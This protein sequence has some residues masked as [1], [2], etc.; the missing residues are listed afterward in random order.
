MEVAEK[1]FIGAAGKA[2]FDADK[3]PYVTAEA[4]KRGNVVFGPYERYYETN[5]YEV[6]FYIL[7]GKDFI[8]DGRNFCQAD[9][10]HSEYP[11]DKRVIAGANINSNASVYEGVMRVTLPFSIEWPGTLQ[12]RLHSLGTHNFAVKYRRDVNIAGQ[13]GEAVEHSE[14]Y[15]A[16]LSNFRR[17]SYL[18]AKITDGVDEILF[19]WLGIRCLIK[20]DEDLAIIND[21]LN[22]NNYKFAIAGEFCVIDI[23]MNVGL[24]SLY[25]ARMPAV[26]A[27]H[28]FEPF[29]RPF[30][31]ALANFALN[32]ELS[33]K[34]KPHQIGLSGKTEV[35]EVAVDPERT[36]GTS[37]RG[38]VAG[39]VVDR[40]SIQDATE[41][42]EPI[43]REA[44]RKKQSIVVKMDCEGSEFGIFDSLQKSGLLR[45][46]NIF[47]I[48]CHK[49]WSPD[50]SNETL[51]K[52]LVANGFS[53]FDFNHM[54]NAGASLIYASRSGVI[55]RPGW[56]AGRVSE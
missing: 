3:E 32:P 41:A 38:R 48:E 42:L 9:V 10:Y 16:N 23:G 4:G 25:F 11:V 17:Y 44:S 45:R 51:V 54:D 20:S 31:R 28:S 33:A 22:L 24:A 2:C 36:I 39:A 55:G 35:L 50:K 47:M 34:I 53:V 46:I 52:P 37:I 56:F 13:T 21:V 40:I 18:G 5:N 8:P 7:I 30:A 27:V 6:T 19:E 1:L 15:G 29:S 14:L 12:F 49:N 26:R 43:I